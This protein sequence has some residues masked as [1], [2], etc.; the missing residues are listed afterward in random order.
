MRLTL[1]TD[2]AVRIVDCIARKGS[3]IGSKEIAETAGVTLQLS[4]KILR[5]LVSHGVVKSYK[6]VHGGYTLAKPPAD[7]VLLD[8][9]ELFEGEL[10]INR[11]VGS[12]YTCTRRHEA[13]CVYHR[14]FDEISAD[15]RQKLKSTT[16][17]AVLASDSNN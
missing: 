10:Y 9:I 1:E 2:Y 15:M 6:G 3:V 17:A 14:L 13:P 16:L 11:C 7:I 8:L 4:L 12:S 5:K